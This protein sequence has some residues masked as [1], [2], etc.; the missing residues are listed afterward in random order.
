[1]TAMRRLASPSR[2]HACH[3]FALLTCAA[4]ALIACGTP[5]VTHFHSLMPAEIGARATTPAASGI[6]VVLEPIRVPA[7]VDQPQWLVQLPQGSAALLE[8]ERWA[9]PLR[10]EFRQALLEELIVGQGV[11]DART[12]PGVVAPPRVDARQ[13]VR[14]SLPAPAL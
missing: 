12:Q 8:Q 3:R 13:R 14:S 6:V 7:Q 10:D 9:S 11:V 5:P 2:L 1:M 4:L